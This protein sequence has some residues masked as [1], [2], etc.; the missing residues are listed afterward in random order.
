MTPRPATP[1]PFDSELEQM[2]IGTIVFNK[3]LSTEEKAISTVDF[4]SIEN[5]RIWGAIMEIDE[6]RQSIEAL[7][8]ASRVNMPAVTGSMLGR[9]AMG[10]PGYLRPSDIKRLKDLAA[11]RQMMRSFSNLIDRAAAKDPVADI[12]AENEL[13]LEQIRD[14]QD[15]QKGTSQHLIEVMENEVFPR[16]DKFVSGEMVRVPFGFPLLDNATNGGSSLGDLVVF[17]ALPKSGKSIIQL[18]TA[19]NIAEQKIQT[20]IASLEM[21]NYEN[22][23]RFLSQSSKYSMNVFRPDM[24]PETAERLKE[25]GR[26]HFHLPLRMDQK[27]RTTKDLALEIRRLQDSEGLTCVFVD[28]VQLVNSTRRHESRTAKIEEAIY[29][30]KEIAMRYEVV[31]YT[32]AQFNREGIKSERPTMAQFDG[33]SAIEKAANLVLFWTLEKEFDPNA[34]GRKGQFWIEAGRS[35][36][37]DEFSIVFDGANSKFSFV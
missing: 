17:G 34:N 6:D 4:F 11:L 7:E 15:T 1:T 2:I 21:L 37:T 12:I 24:Y 32:A 29:E 8:I 25:H 13:L 9:W 36:A 28:Y 27:V 5:Q 31:V 23:F 20:L 18:Q 3:R 19:R 10:L 22:G 16:L 14:T 35:V 26:S 33:S 30:L